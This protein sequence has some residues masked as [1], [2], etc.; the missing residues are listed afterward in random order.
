[1]IEA[2]SRALMQLATC[3]L[4]EG[5]REWA[6]A[7]QA[8]FEEAAE[9]RKSFSFACGCL[10]AAC[11]EL[12]RHS[13]GRLG[14]VSHVLALGLLIPLALFQFGL[15]LGLSTADGGLA[16]GLGPGG[17]QDPLLASP[18]LTAMPALHIL[19]L[20]LGAGHLHLA[21]VLLDRDWER[22][23]KA[24]AL[25]AAA[26]LTLFI[27]MEVLL[28][29]TAGLIVLA[30]ELAIETTFIL[31]LARWHARIFPNTGAVP[32]TTGW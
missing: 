12:P 18:Q 27:F 24:G 9:A 21:W 32:A 15:G 23:A 6:L 10:I 25:I 4:G 8:E 1:M 17:S 30:A 11:G 7:M 13:E 22:V 26:T 28:L 20:M 3:C 29:D 31:A 14:I 5:R 16:V 2:L 19:W